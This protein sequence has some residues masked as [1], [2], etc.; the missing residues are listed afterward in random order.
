[1]AWMHS[2]L[3]Y[4]YLLVSFSEYIS[5][6]TGVEYVANFFFPFGSFKFFLNS[7]KINR[8]AIYQNEAAI[9]HRCPVRIGALATE[10]LDSF[11]SGDAGR[12]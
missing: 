4:D 3:Q 5:F 10:R 6:H 8:R 2:N 11:S 9:K 12:Y 7:D 1:M